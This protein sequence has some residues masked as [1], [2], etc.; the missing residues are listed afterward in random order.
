MPKVVDHDGRRSE[1][2]AAAVTV[3]DRVGIENLRLIDVAKEVGATTGMVTHY[4]GD[5]NSVLKAALEYV[6]G[7]LLEEDEEQDIESADLGTLWEFLHSILPTTDRSRTHWSV[8]LAFWGRASNNSELAEVHERYGEQFRL[9][10]NQTLQRILPPSAFSRTTAEEMANAVIIA[11]DGVS[12]HATL[13]PQA[14]PSEKQK[15]QL[16]IMLGPILGVPRSVDKETKRSNS[17]A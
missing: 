8:W 15:R 5:K 17:N 1:L 12:L 4:L 16:T 3:I 11:I 13:E 2:A 6:A 14:W 7:E 9:S 10:L